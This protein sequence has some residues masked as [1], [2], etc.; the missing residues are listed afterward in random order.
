VYL[1]SELQEETRQLKSKADHETGRPECWRPSGN[2]NRTVNKS[3]R[4]VA[5]TRLQERNAK[6][7]EIGNPRFIRFGKQGIT[8]RPVANQV[9]VTSL[10]YNFTRGSVKSITHQS[11]NTIPPLNNYRWV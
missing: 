11:S 8:A 2:Q 3:Q 6:V 5:L 7:L 1:L 4:N 9:S 10:R